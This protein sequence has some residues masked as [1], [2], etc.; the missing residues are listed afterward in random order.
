MYTPMTTQ[1]Q[2]DAN[3]RN[4]SKST[5]PV[6]DLG[7]LTSRRNALKHGLAGSGLVLPQEDFDAVQLRMAEWNSSLKPFDPYEIWLLEI[8]AVESIRVDRCRIQDRVLRDDQMRH[9]YDFWD[10]DRR[11]EADERIAKLAKNPSVLAKLR[12]TVPGA[13]LLL[14]RWRALARLLENGDWNVAQESLAHDLLGTPAA[15][16]EGIAHPREVTRSE[17]A[18]LEHL[19]ADVLPARNT[20]DCDLRKAGLP[21]LGDRALLLVHRY[22]L[23]CFRRLMW[24]TEQMRSKHR[25]VISSNYPRSDSMDFKPLK[26]VKLSPEPIVETPAKRPDPSIYRRPLLQHSLDTDDLKFLAKTMRASETETSKKG[27]VKKAVRKNLPSLKDRP[28]RRSQGVNA[29]G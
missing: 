15:L 5:G 18:R 25:N 7:K 20:E 2:I 19:I 26:N 14:E 6:S 11:Q 8:V 4:A 22:E 3:R 16:R 12:A 29:S 1:K 17:I 13:S 24:A 9:A 28:S 10:D 27:G 21:D 23:R